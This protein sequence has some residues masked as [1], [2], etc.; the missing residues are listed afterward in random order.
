[1]KTK[2]DD[3]ETTIAND[4]TKHFRKDSI[5]MMLPKLHDYELSLFTVLDP[6]TKQVNFIEVIILPFL[7]LN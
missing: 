4:Q 3:C 5:T 2:I 1:M 7:E 6:M